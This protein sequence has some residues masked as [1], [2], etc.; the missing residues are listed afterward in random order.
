MASNI[1]ASGSASVSGP[2]TNNRTLYTKGSIHGVLAIE[3]D[4]RTAPSSPTTNFWPSYLTNMWPGMRNLSISNFAVGGDTLQAMIGEYATQAHLLAPTNYAGQ[5]GYFLIQGGANDLGTSG[6][7]YGTNV[8][9]YATQ[10]WA[11]ARADGFIVIAST[12]TGAGIGWFASNTAETVIFNNLV[13]SDP[14]LYDYLLEPDIV[15]PLT[16]TDY[17]IDGIHYNDAGSLAFAKMVANTL[18]GPRRSLN[19]NFIT[20]LES[21]SSAGDATVTGRIG[22]GT[23]APSARV[24][25]RPSTPGGT[26]SLRIDDT[27]G[28]PRFQFG[29]FSASPGLAGLW[30]GNITPSL[31]NYG[32]LGDGTASLYFNAP[33]VLQFSTASSVRWQVDGSGHFVAVADNTYDIGS[34]GTA[35]PRNLYLAGNSTIAGNSFVT[36]NLLAQGTIGIGTN[37]VSSAKFVLEADNSMPYVFQ[38]GT[39]N[40]QSLFTGDTNGNLTVQSLR[41]DYTNS[42]PLFQF[43]VLSSAP[44]FASLWCGNITPSISNYNILGDGTSALYMNAP[45]VLYLQTASITRWQIDVSGHLTTV[46]D[47]VYDIGA[48]G[49]SRPRNL[50]IAGSESVGGN[51]SIIGNL[52]VQG[53]FGIGTNSVSASKFQVVAGNASGINV[54]QFG[55]TNKPSL[56]VGDTN[57]ILTL[58]G[59][60]IIVGGG[61]ATLTNTLYAS[62]T[63]DFPSTLAQTDSDLPITV[64]G[65][66]SGDIV[67]LGAPT[68]P[69]TGSTYTA[70]ASNDTVFV[71]FSVYGLAAKDPASGTFRIR[72]DKFK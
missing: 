45:S 70:F 57:G 51:S 53:S 64:T 21:V 15:T 20:R 13:R 44:Q 33:T 36:G 9:S 41:I 60:G 18:T 49:A 58:S 68:V 1:I 54:F 12:E 32:L 66:A 6:I 4:S 14:T 43:G 23:N 5:V 17:Y 38:F 56:Y 63:L 30:F 22:A 10:I 37:S 69:L 28:T 3:G 59:G 2:F 26:S 67:S 11:K 71:R 61:T 16:R 39:T 19:T 35:R 55:T 52:L 40:K 48:S 8:Y 42:T 72:V 27:N 46:T 7:G 50:Y 25:I 29:V 47:N 65:A 24:H 62:A 31:S 34:S